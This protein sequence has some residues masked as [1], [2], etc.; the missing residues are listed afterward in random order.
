MGYETAGRVV[1]ACSPVTGE[2]VMQRLT[3]VMCWLILGAWLVPVF[4]QPAQDARNTLQGT[5]TAA[6]AERDGKAADDVIGNRLSF[7]GDRFQ[8]RSND[9]KPL[10][11]GTFR[12]N[13]GTK[14][15]AIDFAH[16]EGA[17]KGQAWKGIF[18]VDGD[19]LRICDNAPN[20]A[21]SRP[22][23]FEAKSGSG[24]VFITFK[25]AKP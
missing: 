25:R 5:W 9:G 10:Y 23:S 7:T 18:A 22:A 20:L 2:T 19:R 13:P 14:P 6:E 12:V 24:H 3:S 11:A 16:T 1:R 17:L 15:A 21:K 8:I 4:A